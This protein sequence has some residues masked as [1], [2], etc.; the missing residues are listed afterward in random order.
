MEERGREDEMALAAALSISCCA[1]LLLLSLSPFGF[2][3]EERTDEEGDSKKE[4]DEIGGRGGGKG[5][6]HKRDEENESGSPEIG[7]Y[8]RRIHIL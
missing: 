8:I 1:A 7:T 4:E 6:R 2:V 5:T 3:C